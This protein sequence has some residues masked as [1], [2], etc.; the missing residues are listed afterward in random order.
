MEIA[1]VDPVGHASS[2][3]WIFRDPTFRDDVESGGNCGGSCGNCGGGNERNESI[4]N[5]SAKIIV[6]RT[7]I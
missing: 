4:V 2:Q 7:F 1:F 6:L 3:R 5:Q